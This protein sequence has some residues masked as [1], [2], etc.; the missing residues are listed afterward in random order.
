MRGFIDCNME[1]GGYRLFHQYNQ[2]T[3]AKI[4]NR[5][6]E[7]F[8]QIMTNQSIFYSGIVLVLGF[9]IRQ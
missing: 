6:K 9:L 7:R 5:R 8:G 4:F 3:F 1:Y 2:Y